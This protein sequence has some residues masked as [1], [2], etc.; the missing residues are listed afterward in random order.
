M[1]QRQRD[2]IRLAQDFRRALRRVRI[3]MARGYSLQEA[4]ASITAKLSDVKAPKPK[5]QR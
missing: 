1:N 2:N 5:A 3:S 4:I